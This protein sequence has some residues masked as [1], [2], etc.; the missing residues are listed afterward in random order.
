MFIAL[1]LLFAQGGEMAPPET[2]VRGQYFVKPTYGPVLC[3]V[4]MRVRV[5]GKGQAGVVTMPIPSDYSG[6]T[7]VGFRVTTQP[8][9]ALLGWTWR[10]RA[11]GLNR[12]AEVHVQPGAG[13]VTVSYTARMLIPGFNVLRTERKDF[14]NWLGETVSVPST[15][16]DWVEVSKKLQEGKPTPD[17]FMIRVVKWVANLNLG[18]ADADQPLKRAEICA[19]IFRAAKIPARLV[20]E[21]PRV[22]NRK[23]SIHWRVEIQSDER[24]WQ[25]VDPLVGVSYPVR[26]SAAVLAIP[27]RKDESHGPIASAF[28]PS[29]PSFSTPEISSELAWAA[30]G[31]NRLTELTV[32][33]TFPMA[34]GARVMAAAYHRS[35]LLADVARKGEGMWIEDAILRHVL[36][37][38]AT[39][40]ALYLDGKPTMPDK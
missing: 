38:G 1:A 2:P 27:S 36:L 10:N 25:A 39:N 40:L 20:A 23:F 22:A 4:G 24:T 33:R 5:T 37:K 14:K 16:A 13:N 15:N 18:S 21:V 32:I 7:V 19:A 35:L 6:Q 8:P 3:D 11:D 34:N 31:G 30:G 17:E 28:D 29:A 26:N 12:V 9:Q